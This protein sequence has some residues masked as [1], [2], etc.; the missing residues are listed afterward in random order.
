[1]QCWR[2][3]VDGCDDD[4]WAG[5]GGRVGTGLSEGVGLISKMEPQPGQVHCAYDCPRMGV[6]HQRIGSTR[7]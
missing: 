4:E 7:S 3:K 6:Q 5:R 2:R 1:M